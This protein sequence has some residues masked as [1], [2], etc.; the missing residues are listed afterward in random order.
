MHDDTHAGLKVMLAVL[1][2]AAAGA[3]HAGTW[4]VSKNGLESNTGNLSTSPYASITNALA[5]ATTNDAILVSAGVYSQTV[6]FASNKVAIAKHWRASGLASRSST[7]QTMHF[8]AII[9]GSR[10]KLI[11]HRLI[12]ERLGAGQAEI[13]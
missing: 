6:A 13:S 7:R 1:L 9:E 5:H 3:T 11:R 8:S 2:M 4:Y 10:S 12:G